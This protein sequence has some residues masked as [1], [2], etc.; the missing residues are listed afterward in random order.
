MNLLD[1]EDNQRTDF[2]DKSE[3]PTFVDVNANLLDLDSAWPPQIYQV[4]VPETTPKFI[5]FFS[6]LE[7]ST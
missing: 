6:Y 7:Y 4:A 5:G 3:T 1:F 2:L